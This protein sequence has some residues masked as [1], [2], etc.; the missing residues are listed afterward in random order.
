VTYDSSAV[1]L[2]AHVEMVCMFAVACLPSIPKIFKTLKGTGIFTTFKSWASSVRTTS[3]TS[4]R[5]TTW[6]DPK[7][8]LPRSYHQID[9]ES[10]ANLTKDGPTTLSRSRNGPDPTQEG[11]VLTTRVTTRMEEN[12]DFNAAE[13]DYHRQHPW[14]T[15]R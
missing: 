3:T 14:A 15:H 6:T 4:S 13:D 7:G 11:I 1:A 12:N 9:E 2:W 8:T 5:G 10:T